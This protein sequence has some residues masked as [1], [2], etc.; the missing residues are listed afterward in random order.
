MVCPPYIRSVHTERTEPTVPNLFFKIL[1]ADYT[2]RTVHTVRTVRT[3]PTVRTIRTE[4]TVRKKIIKKIVN[5][6]PYRAYRQYR[7]YR[8]YR[9]YRPLQKTR[10]LLA[11]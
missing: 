1:I 10:L 3:E 7:E 4:P 8:T 5:C 2:G 6:R 11:Q 9:T